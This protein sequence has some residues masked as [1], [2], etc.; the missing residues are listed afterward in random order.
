MQPKRFGIQPM[1]LTINEHHRIA[2]R[3]QANAKTCVPQKRELCFKMAALHLA[4][5]RVQLERPELRPGRSIK[6]S[7]PPVA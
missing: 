5:A 1:K 4:L 6:A 2:K 7:S 3:L